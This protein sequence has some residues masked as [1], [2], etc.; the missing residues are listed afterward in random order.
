MS[1]NRLLQRYGHGATPLAI[2]PTC[3][4]VVMVC[5]KQEQ[6]QASNADTVVLRF[7]KGPYVR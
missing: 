7:G 1:D 4:E 5:G 6:F 2:N 3:T